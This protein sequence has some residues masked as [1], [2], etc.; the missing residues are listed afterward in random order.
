MDL[1]V[2]QQS[3]QILTGRN[4]KYRNQT[5]PGAVEPDSNR[6]RDNDHAPSANQLA[7]N[8]RGRAPTRFPDPSLYLSFYLRTRCFDNRGN[9]FWLT[10]DIRH[11]DIV[12]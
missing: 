10:V 5:H 3:K 1:F 4:Q 8:G 7:K 6:D 9:V 12:P 11:D 2:N